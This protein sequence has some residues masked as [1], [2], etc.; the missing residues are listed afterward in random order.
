MGEATNEWQLASLRLLQPPHPLP[1]LL[2][3]AVVGVVLVAVGSG[4][5]RAQ[6]YIWLKNEQRCL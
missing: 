1:R 3:R 4:A 6:G 5:Y 2:L